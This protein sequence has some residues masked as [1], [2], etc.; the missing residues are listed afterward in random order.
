MLS[1]YLIDAMPSGNVW[2]VTLSLCLLVIA[3]TTFVSH[4]VASIILLPIIV[5]LSI[6]IGH[7]H[8]PVICCALSIS[9]AMALPFSSFPNINS[10]LV[11]DDHGQPYLRVVDFVRVGV[12]FSFITVGLIV[13][14]GYFLIVVVIGFSTPP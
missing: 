11:L 6:Q 9:A 14:F 13:S 5:D 10:L 12:G 3:L 1:T 8:I 7:P 4:T 2:L